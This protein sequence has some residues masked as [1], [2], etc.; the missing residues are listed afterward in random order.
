MCVCVYQQFDLIN[1]LFQHSLNLHLYHLKYTKRNKLF[2]D[3]FYFLFIYI[4]VRIETNSTFEMEI[5]DLQNLTIRTQSID[6]LIWLASVVQIEFKQTSRKILIVANR[7]KS[8][9]ITWSLTLKFKLLESLDRQ[10]ISN[11]YLSFIIFIAFKVHKT[12]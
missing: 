1:C 12:W 5:F 10:Q 6:L 7:R 3:I 4:R 11:A 9:R 2:I 8:P